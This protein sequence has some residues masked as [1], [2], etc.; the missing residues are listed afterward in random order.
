MGKSRAATAA[1]YLL[2]GL[3]VALSVV[4]LLVLSSGLTFFQDTWAYL[5]Y[6]RDFSAAAF[7]DPHNEHIVVIPVAIE[8]LFVELFGMSSALPEY[9]LL[10]AMLV[11]TALLLFVYVRRRLGPWPAL[12][13]TVLVLFLGPAWDVLL[14]PFEIAL[15]GSTMTG[16]GVLLALEREDR[17]G[18][19]AACLL[20]VLS[21]GF[22]S[23]GIAFAVAA[24]VDVLQ[25][26]RTL[27]LGRL[28]VPAV[29][30]ALY[31]AWY[32]GY[33]HEAKSYL[34][35]HNVLHAPVFVVQ[36]I[37]AS[38][39]A[40]SGLTVLSDD[41]GGRPYLGFALLVVLTALLAWKLRR[42]PPLTSRF[43]PVAAAAGTFWVLAAI[44]RSPGREAMASRY[45]HFGGI[46]V[47]LAL[48]D[49]LK[50]ARFGVRAL[51][52]AAA[53]VLAVTAINFQELERGSD[54]LE[55][56]TVLTRA[57]L[58]AMEIA[59]ET[60][61]PYFFL[62]PEVA[63]TP[64][65]IDVNATAYFPAAREH[66]TPAYTPAELAAAPE[67]G[68]AQADVVLAAALPVALNAGPTGRGGGL[69][70]CLGL[71]G[72]GANGALRV[73]PGTTTIQLDPGPRASVFL[74]RFAA[75]GFPVFVG[76]VEGGS[77]VELVIPADKAQRP[78]RLLV[79]ASQPARVCG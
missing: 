77:T 36:G 64:S 11:V 46:L 71:P 26:R 24:F 21:I 12:F 60:I 73:G 8:K 41:P 19:L 72:G 3:T 27:G 56:Q 31:A 33:G 32:L 45:M 76:R 6:R 42:L 69:G 59:R 4:A 5:M 25:R 10:D 18:D 75:E 70:G 58:G 9:L 78:W 44:N 51:L 54:H 17:R 67:E 62:S 16:I 63:G 43:W 50:G 22:S 39:G 23:L 29:A 74:R 7:L 65:L 52:V 79:E 30:L 53:V 37:S 57:D 40:L 68:R 2:L 13:A 20:L 48:A 1:P 61:S 28:Y 47:L 34:S 14:W 35:V 15:V 49:L 38:V 55:D 66:G